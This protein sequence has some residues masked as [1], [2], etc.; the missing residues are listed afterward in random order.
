MVGG[1]DKVLGDGDAAG[2]NATARIHQ[3]GG[4]ARLFGSIC[5]RI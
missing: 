3:H 4:F 1:Q 5:H 2:R